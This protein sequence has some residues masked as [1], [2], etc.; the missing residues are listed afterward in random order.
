MSLSLRVTRTATRLRRSALISPEALHNRAGEVRRP[1]PVPRAISRRCRIERARIKGCD[2]ITLRPR[3]GPAPRVQTLYL[4]GG[5][6]VSTLTSI[7]WWIIASLMRRAQSTMTV[8]LYQTAPQ[9]TIDDAIPLL[10]E[11]AASLPKE[12]RLTY[13]G[14]S[15][16][17][18]LAL[19]FAMHQRDID[20]ESKA[21]ALVLFS[22]WVDVTMRNPDIGLYQE[23]DGILNAEQLRTC[24]AWWA[25]KRD[26]TDPAV[27]PLLGDLSGL[28]PVRIFQGDHDIFAPDVVALD[29]RIRESGGNCDLR[30]VRGGFHVFVGAPWVP[31]SR[32]ALDQ[33]AD[34]IAHEH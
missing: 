19:S 23:R 26:V 28:P 12:G 17:G 34:T 4:H 3:Q 5:A 1:A 29:A 6:Y 18:G 22:P 7:H 2:V 14:D 25:G 32:R 21:D 24:G 30:M 10:D 33:T 31:E 11:L 20:A 15:A 16:G 8:P 13:V 9:H 27:S